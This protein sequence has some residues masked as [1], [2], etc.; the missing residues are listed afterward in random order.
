MVATLSLRLIFTVF[1]P[2]TQQVS[3]KLFFNMERKTFAPTD[4][5]IEGKCSCDQVLPFPYVTIQ[6]TCQSNT[7]TGIKVYC[8]FLFQWPQC[9]FFLLKNSNCM[10]CNTQNCTSVRAAQLVL[11]YWRVPAH[12]KNLSYCAC[13]NNNMVATL[14]HHRSNETASLH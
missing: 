14:F 4:T 3:Q 9:A 5:Y 11:S 13:R 10:K 1:Y 12:F 8:L 7:K 6:H 2:S